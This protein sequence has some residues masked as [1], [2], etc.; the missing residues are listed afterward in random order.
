MLLDNEDLKLARMKQSLEEVTVAKNMHIVLWKSFACQ[1]KITMQT[2][3][4]NNKTDGPALL[5]HLLH[6]CMATAESVIRTYQ[7]PL[8]ILL[9]KL[10]EVGFD[11]NRFCEYASEMLKTLCDARG[12][13]KQ[14]P[15]ELYKVLVPTNVD[16][17]SSETRSYKAAVA[18]KDKLFDFTKLTTIAH[19]EYTSLIMHGQMN[20][21]EELYLKDKKYR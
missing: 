14:S 6:Q 7:S 5:Y 21:T 3:P 13:G 9:E 16:A 19:T 12:I 4:G 1:I 18:T 20:L 10:E 8:N 17:Y 2:V 15:F 11:V